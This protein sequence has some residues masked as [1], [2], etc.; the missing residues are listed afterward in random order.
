MIK[1]TQNILQLKNLFLDVIDEG[2]KFD[3]TINKNVNYEKIRRID[4]EKK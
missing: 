3:T 4:V 1:K 2:F